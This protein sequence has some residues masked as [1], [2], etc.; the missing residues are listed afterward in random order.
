M[1]T[2]TCHTYPALLQLPRVPMDLVGA[3]D[4]VT[5]PPHVHTAGLP[6]DFAGQRES[7]LVSLTASDPQ[8]VGP[9]MA[10]YAFDHIIGFGARLEVRSSD[11]AMGI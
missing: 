6:Q 8:R 1:N 7:A 5:L 3:D 9:L 10:A 11:E 2:H 4:C